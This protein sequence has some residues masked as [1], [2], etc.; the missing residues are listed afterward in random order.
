M[1][2]PTPGL[3]ALPSALRANGPELS[4]LLASGTRDGVA[5]LD[6]TGQLLFWNTAA[7]SITGWSFAEAATRGLGELAQTSG[8]LTLIRDSKWVEVRSVVL[9]AGSQRFRLVMFTDSTPHVRLRDTR[10]QLLAL[11]L[12]DSRT[13]FVG[14]ELAMVHLEHAIALAARDKR[15]VGALAVKVDRLRDLRG[16][17]PAIAEEAVRQLAQRVGAFVRASDVPARLADDSFLVVLT[18]MTSS[19]DATIVA[20]RLLLALAEPFD[21]VGQSRSLQCSIGVAE[22]P[23][24]A[25]DATALLSAA[26]GAADRAQVLGGGRF[27]LA[28]SRPAMPEVR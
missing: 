6:A 26:L 8:A 15:S 4:A 20:E 19:N 13:N 7:V 17:D 12:I 14:R 24:D 1:D 21:V 16:A 3:S 9:E 10:D 27:C 25:A 18:A 2:Q 23:R 22:A 5:I 28:P 11:S